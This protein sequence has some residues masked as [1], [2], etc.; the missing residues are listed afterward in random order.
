MPYTL[1]CG[2]L[3]YGQ[4]RKIGVGHT[5]AAPAALGLGAYAS[6]GLRGAF[7]NPAHMVSARQL[8]EQLTIIAHETLAEGM[9]GGWFRAT[10]GKG[11]AP[12]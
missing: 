10:L 3:P 6:L 2:G 8:I 1:K 11:G 7:A 12:P 4:E 5:V 9:D